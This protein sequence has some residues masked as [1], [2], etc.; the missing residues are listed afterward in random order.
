MTLLMQIIDAK[1]GNKEFALFFD[2]AH[3]WTAAIGNQSQNV[4]LGEI[5]AEFEATGSTPDEALSA[6][7]DMIKQE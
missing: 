7:F 6:L 2:G 3:E 1:A 4:R 5:D